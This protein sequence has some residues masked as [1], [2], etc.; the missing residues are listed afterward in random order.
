MERLASAG[1]AWGEGDYAFSFK[2]YF[3]ESFE[4]IEIHTFFAILVQ[5]QQ[6]KKSNQMIR[7]LYFSY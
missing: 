1:F 3:E 2:D 4:L 5:K 6:H 7:N